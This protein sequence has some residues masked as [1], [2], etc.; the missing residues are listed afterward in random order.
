MNNHPSRISTHENQTTKIRAR[1]NSLY[2][3]LTSACLSIFALVGSA[4]GASTIT[5]Q[6]VN[7]SGPGSLRQ[8]VL[9]AAALYPTERTTINFDSTL[10]HKVILLTSGPIVLEGPVVIMGPGADLL[11]ISGNHQSR[12]F[13]LPPSTSSVNDI[14]NLTLAD[15][16]DPG[17]SGGHGGAVLN[18]R[19]AHFVA[20]VFVGNSVATS[21]TG[22]SHGGAIEN[23]YFL[24]ANNCTFYNN[25]AQG[26][27]AIYSSGSTADC[28]LTLC[29]FTKNS[30][31]SPTGAG[32]GAIIHRG[33]FLNVNMCTIA[34][35]T[36][37]GVG[38]G[39]YTSDVPQNT[40]GI[41][42]SIIA[43]NH[44]PSSPDTYGA[45]TSAGFNL[46]GLSDTGNGFTQ[47]TD[48][49]GKTTPIDPKL[50]AL[51][52]NGG[53][54]P[55]MALQPNSPA[56]DS[57]NAKSITI[58]QRYLPRTVDY[59]GVAPHNSGGDFSD[60]GAF[61]LAAPS[62]LLNISTRLRVLTNDNALIGGFI[63]TGTQ[64][65]DVIIR[66]IGPSLAGS[67]VQGAL[68]D[69]VLELHQG[70]STLAIND[71]WKETQQAEIQVT[72]LAP[73]NDLESA[74]VANL[75]PGA[76]TAI[77]RGK[78]DTLGVG[79]IEVYDLHEAALATLANISTRGFV[80]TGDNAM[81]GG[82]I[83]GGEPGAD[84]LS[85]IVIR[86]LGPSLQDFGVGNALSD[87][88]LELH[89]GQGAVIQS[90]DNWKDSQQ[91]E[92]SQSGLA[93]TRDAE[94]AISLTISQGLY[95]VILRGKDNSTGVGV[96]EVYNLR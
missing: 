8:A 26:G 15:G 6:N 27:G 24:S 73:T 18:G 76:Y 50:N 88:T 39:L 36:A 16:F 65:K 14:S 5:V 38:G 35:N 42:S 48:L 92:I 51:A 87:P 58:D 11:T 54:V 55:T 32:G 61:E 30:V 12:I 53:R 91:A 13:T 60:I 93:P 19:V 31:S 62:T 75:Q 28:L 66:G 49:F 47:S 64:P 82:F 40:S 83:A 1:S 41:R 85:R 81:I 96:V 29:T 78:N 20:C 37:D 17:Q 95:T 46:V 10:L 23:S 59:P 79:L 25:S 86:G 69:P 33:R 77:L 43:S 21:P 84:G 52:N 45:Y 9:D 72:T 89:D 56:V 70:D 34:D 57:G 3:N 67:G 68:A 44:A 80:D 94:S 90:N 71:N 4:P 7:D 63:I 22:D 74:I 2:L